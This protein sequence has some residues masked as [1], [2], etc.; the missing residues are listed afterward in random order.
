MA[1]QGSNYRYIIYHTG[2]I[3]SHFLHTFILVKASPK[4]LEP[5]EPRM[6]NVAVVCRDEVTAFKPFLWHQSEFEKVCF[7]SDDNVD[8]VKLECVGNT[9]A[10]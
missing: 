6:Y 10:R 9:T 3:K 1:K 2:C 4:P 5:G 8:K 7:H